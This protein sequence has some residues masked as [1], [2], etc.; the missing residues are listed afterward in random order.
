MKPVAE[1]LDHA[2]RFER[3]AAEAANPELKAQFLRQSEAYRKLASKR[4]VQL[5]AKPPNGSPPVP[6]NTKGP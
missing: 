6:N 3:M 2:L 1:Y 4:A 5:K